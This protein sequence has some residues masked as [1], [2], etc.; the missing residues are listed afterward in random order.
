MA[1]TNILFSEEQGF[2]QW[3]LWIII[4]GVL[5]SLFYTTYQSYEASGS[6]FQTDTLTLLLMSILLP[7]LFYALKLKTRITTEGIYV[8]FVPFHWKEKFISFSELSDCYVRQYSP[9][10]EFGG[11]GIKYGLGGAGKVYNVSG[12]MGLQLVYQDGSKLLI[13]SNRTEEIQKILADL[14]IFGHPKA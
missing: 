13:G 11:W 1:D 10:G 14:K 2:T 5:G 12:N 3:W 6:L 8:R 7:A 9:I 4:Y